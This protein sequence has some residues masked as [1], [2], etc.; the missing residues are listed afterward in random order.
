MIGI[1]V[2]AFPLV[3]GYLWAQ[4]AGRHWTSAEDGEHFDQDAYD[5]ALAD[6]G[7]LPS[8]T[9]A[10]APILVPI[11]LIAIGSVANFPG[12]PLGEGTVYTLFS[13][14]GKPINALF[15]GFFLSLLLLP[16]LTKVTTYDWI[17]DGLKSAAIIIMITGAGGGLGAIL[18]ATEI[19]D[20]LGNMLASYNLGIFLPFLIAAA[21]KTAQGSSTVALV[22]TSALVAPM[23]GALGLDETMGRVL[24]VMAIGAGAMTVSHANDSYFWVVTQFSK[25]DVAT[26][27]KAQ[28]V[29]T[30]LQGLTGMSVVAI[31]SWIIL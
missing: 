4:F 6:Y 16:E 5:K 1:L 8:A 23:L 9:K 22:A 13:F 10:F 12:Q 19:G 18:K 2:S 30:L 25:M 11:V 21:F 20:N 7:E 24:T 17:E 27:Y 3:A 28:T 14:L 15:I 31:L 29:A 26:A